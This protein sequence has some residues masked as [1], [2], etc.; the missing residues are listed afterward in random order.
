MTTDSMWL[1]RHF[2]LLWIIT[3]AVA[4]ADLVFVG[5][6]L[7]LDS[8]QWASWVQALGSIAAILGAFFISARQ[9]RDAM[10]ISAQQSKD[11]I[12]AIR[13][14]DEIAFERRSRSVV[15]IAAIATDHARMCLHMCSD[16]RWYYL[17]FHWIDYLGAS[18]RMVHVALLAVQP[19]ELGSV[20]A[21]SAWSRLKTEIEWIQQAMARADAYADSCEQTG[22]DPVRIDDVAMIRG[23]A[24]MIVAASDDLKA[25]LI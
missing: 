1:N 21:I 14:A 23:H 6:L 12:A 22:N 10:A 9:S 11:A 17:Q 4:L 5:H 7:G 25:A 3:A 15:S 13:K 19:T 24:E 18:F 2:R 8:N 20:E 16:T